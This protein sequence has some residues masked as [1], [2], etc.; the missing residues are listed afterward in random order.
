G[1]TL[2]V[3][4]GAGGIGTTAIQLGRA[5]G[6]RVFATAGSPEKCT[7]CESLGA[8][9]AIDYRREDFVAV[10]RELTGGRGVD[11]ILDILGGE[12]LPSREGGRGSSAHGVARARGQDRAHGVTTVASGARRPPFQWIV[13]GLGASLALLFAAAFVLVARHGGREGHLGWRPAPAS[14]GG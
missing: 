12:E 9:K 13:L 8:E 1:E 4:G 6:A 3:H 11:V 7:V 2:L 5:F 14:D 10:I